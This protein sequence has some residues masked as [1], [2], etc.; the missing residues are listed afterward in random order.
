MLNLIVNP[1][2]NK[3]RGKRLLQK[4]E[5]KLK[6]EGVAYHIFRPEARG[7]TTAYVREITRQGETFI[8]AMGGDGTLNEVLQGIHDTSRVRLGLIPAGTGNDFA[9]AVN[10]PKGV[11]ALDLI[12]HSEPKFTDY[13]EFDDNR[14]SINIAGMGIDVDILERCERVKVWGRKSK[15]FFSLLVSLCKYRAVKM[16]VSVDGESKEY[17]ALIAAVCNGS[18]FGGGIRV[19]PVAE[20][21]DGKLDVVI[22]DCPKRHKIPVELL[23][24]MRGKIL[25]RKI[26]H[27]FRCDSVEIQTDEEGVA[28]YDGELMPSNGLKAKIISNTLRFYRG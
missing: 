6:E 23:Y 27:H 5:A 16:C 22:A 4:V 10:I 13:I 14:R 19:C 7:A 18:Q 28:Q 21:D 26:L 1:K 25:S 8:V 12:L 17:H 24:L 11:K 15:Y 20:V 9:A 3:G 2:A